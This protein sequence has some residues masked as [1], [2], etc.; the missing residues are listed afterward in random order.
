M[1]S[2]SRTRSHN[3][4]LETRRCNATFRLNQFSQRVINRWNALPQHVVN[5]KTIN[6]FKSQLDKLDV[7][8]FIR[9]LSIMR[10]ADNISGSELL[11]VWKLSVIIRFYLQERNQ[12]MGKVLSA[13]PVN[14]EGGLKEQ[15]FFV[16]S[17][18]SSRFKKSSTKHMNFVQTA[19]F[20]WSPWQPKG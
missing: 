5:A 17:P 1:L 16:W 20:D 18:G 2:E 3:Y 4:K 9:V 13:T 6:S 10:T 14:Y 7:T 8:V 15:T 11:P 19:E 12:I